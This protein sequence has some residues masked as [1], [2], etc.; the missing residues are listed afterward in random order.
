MTSR[1]IKIQRLAR[2]EE[3]EI[4][5]RIVFLSAVSLVLAIVLFTLG[6]SLLG[7]FADLLGLIFKGK[8]EAVSEAGAPTAPVLDDL[9]EATNSAKLTVK[10]FISEGEKVEIYLGENKVGDAK[11][12]GSKFEYEDVS[13]KDGENKISAKTV[14]ADKTSNSSKVIVVV[15]DTLEPK[16]EI[17]SPTE[18]QTFTGNNRVKVM[19]KTDRDAQV[20]ANGFLASVDIEGKFEV[21]VPVAEGE[22]TIE[23]KAV[24]S[25]GNIKIEKRKITFR[26]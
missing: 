17:E 19:G 21:L 9:P 25:A 14:R 18:D 12:E 13:L 5:R 23:I 24:D 7:K 6:I 8:Q 16:L 2:R 26:K 3:K 10:G 22:S 11:I 1:R 20:Y 4:L 15:L